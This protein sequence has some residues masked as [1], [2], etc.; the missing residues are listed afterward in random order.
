MSITKG[1][2]GEMV[3]S[4]D[5]KSLC[6]IKTEWNIDL[7]KATGIGLQTGVGMVG[8]EEDR[9]IAQYYLCKFLKD[10]KEPH[11]CFKDTYVGE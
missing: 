4:T 8:G 10:T 5:G 9:F 3:V 11:I 1:T 6:S 2:E 7:I